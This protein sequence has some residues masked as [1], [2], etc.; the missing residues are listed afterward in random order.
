MNNITEL[1]KDIWLTCSNGARKRDRT[2][3]GL[4]VVVVIS[5]TLIILGL[6]KP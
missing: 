5:V 3:L 4:F 1:I 6:V 2:V